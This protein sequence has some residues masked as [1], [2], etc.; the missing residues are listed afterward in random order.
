MRKEQPGH[1]ETAPWVN[2]RNDGCGIAENS[3][4]INYKIKQNAKCILR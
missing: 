2:S 1:N 4:N 3:T